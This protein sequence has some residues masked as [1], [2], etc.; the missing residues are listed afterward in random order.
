M[1]TART[2]PNNK[3]DIIQNN[4]KGTCKLIDMQSEETEM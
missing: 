3:I 4:E 1:K 2:V